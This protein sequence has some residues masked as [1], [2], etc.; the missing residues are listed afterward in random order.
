MT[1]FKINVDSSS[2]ARETVKKTAKTGGNWFKADGGRPI[3]EV[4]TQARAKRATA[5]AP[6]RLTPAT[7]IHYRSEYS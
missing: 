6:T 1:T 5:H 3:T 2:S 4:R 7:L